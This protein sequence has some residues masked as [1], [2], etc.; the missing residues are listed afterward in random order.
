[1]LH[2]AL[3]IEQWETTNSTSDRPVAIAPKIQYFLLTVL[4]TLWVGIDPAIGQSSILDFSVKVPPTPAQPNPKPTG[5]EVETLTAKLFKSKSAP[6]SVAIAVAEGNLTAKGDRTTAYSGHKDPGNNAMNRGFCS[7]NGADNLTVKQADDRCLAS[8]QDRS[9]GVEKKLQELGVDLEEFPEVL[10][11]GTDLKNQSPRAGADFADRYV[12]AIA[13]GLS[14]QKATI[15]ARVESFRNEA[16]ELSA[17]GLFRIC[18]RNSYYQSQL[19]GLQANSEPWRWNCIALDQGRR[20]RAVQKALDIH[21]DRG[22]FPDALGDGLDFSG[23]NP[24]P[25][26]GAID[27]GVLNFELNPVPG[28]AMQP[29][30]DSTQW[31]EPTNQNQILPDRGSPVLDFNGP[32]PPVTVETPQPPVSKPVVSEKDVFSGKAI[33]QTG[34]KF[35]R[36]RITDYRRFRS[37]HPVPGMPPRWHHGVDVGCG[38]THDVYSPVTGTLKILPPNKTGG[39]GLVARI[40]TED[41]WT[42]QNMHM[43]QI[44]A[45]AGDIKAGDKLGIGGAPKGHPNAGL[46]TGPHSHYERFQVVDG[47]RKYVNP[48]DTEIKALLG[49][50]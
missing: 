49:L 18:R 42:I 39:G 8:L 38:G 35:G 2:P 5:V 28:D 48:T 22:E 19:Q 41:G 37:V 7:W 47:K 15:H 3:Y 12:E 9:L 10:V 21:L 27:S 29:A 4:A 25:T 33:V 44:S 6:G 26:P 34:Q 45:P 46:G 16:G 30:P 20:V 36:C 14:G 40:V 23:K 13:E 24:Q 1:M 17:S 11:N 32:G 43:L 31:Q 50:M